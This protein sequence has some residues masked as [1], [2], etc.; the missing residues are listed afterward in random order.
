MK[1]AILDPAARGSP[2]HGSLAARLLVAAG[3]ALSV[4]AARGVEL[5]SSP[6]AST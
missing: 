2:V 1:S 6:T 5:F 3:P 4:A